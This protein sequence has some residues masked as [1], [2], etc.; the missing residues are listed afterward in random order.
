MTLQPGEKQAVPVDIYDE[1]TKADKVIEG[2][3]YVVGITIDQVDGEGNHSK[4][5]AIALECQIPFDDLDALPSD[6]TSDS[7]ITLAN[8]NLWDGELKATGGSTGPIVL[9]SAGF[10]IATASVVKMTGLTGDK[11]KRKKHA[12]TR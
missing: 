4:V 2:G 3:A 11:L 1:T 12:E 5:N 8:R 7:T 6:S 9:A 10:V